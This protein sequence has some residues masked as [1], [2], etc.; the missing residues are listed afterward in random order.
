MARTVAVAGKGGSGKTTF[1]ALIVRYLLE[2]EEKPL[3]AVD[4]D[5]NSNLNEALG[6]SPR[7][8]LGNI[9]EEMKTE[10]FEGGLSKETWLEVQAEEAI[11]EGEGVDLLVMGRPEG[12][13]C[14]CAV[15]NL[16]RAYLDR[17]TQNYQFVVLDNEAGLEHLNRRLSRDIDEFV[18]LAEPTKKGLLTAQRL[19]E[20]AKSLELTIK[21]FFLVVNKVTEPFNLK[22]EI[23]GVKYLGE[24][25]FDPV[26]VEFEMTGQPCLKLPKDSLAVKTSQELLAQVF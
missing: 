20:L 11:S 9:V 18:I 10:A 23:R 8:T 6:M 24:L 17:L 13:G 26:V 7:K 21:R 15:N 1:S 19:F 4:A 25:P 3:L 16:L 22:E 12:P 2:K 5:P 14:Y